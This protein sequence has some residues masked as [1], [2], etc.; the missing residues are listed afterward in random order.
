ML[1]CKSGGVISWKAFT[2]HYTFTKILDQKN[3]TRW[4]ARWAELLA[5]YHII[6]SCRK[7]TQNIVVDALSRRVDYI[8]TTTESADEWRELRKAYERD[9]DFGRIVELKDSDQYD[10]L[11][12]TNKHWN[13]N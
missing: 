1:H 3:L 9:L 5:E 11:S 2:D 12:H 6:I 8:N 10:H 7:G 13:T 4:Q